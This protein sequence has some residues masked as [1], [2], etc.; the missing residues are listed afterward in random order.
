MD[1][2][3]YRPSIGKPINC[4]QAIANEKQLFVILHFE[5]F[6]EIAQCNKVYKTVKFLTA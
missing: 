2:Y 3:L 6:I 4:L 5:M 1:Y